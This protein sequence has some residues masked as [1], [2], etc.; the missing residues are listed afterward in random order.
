[1]IP[2]VL[3]VI[4][5]DSTRELMKIFFL[6]ITLFVAAIAPLRAD[7]FTQRNTTLETRTTGQNGSTHDGCRTVIFIFHASFTGTVGGQAF[8]S[9]DVPLRLEAQSQDTLRAIPF[10]VTAGSVV[11]VEIR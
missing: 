8:T 9:S 11:V 1:L 6:V 7:Q 10:T 2:T 5:S 3:S 4:L